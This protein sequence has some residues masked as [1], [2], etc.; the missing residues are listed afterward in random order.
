MKYN[1]NL[2]ISFYITCNSSATSQR[3]PSIILY[4]RSDEIF[5]IKF[6]RYENEIF[7]V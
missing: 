1:R 5:Q 4:D 2:N 6:N 7:Q 3:M